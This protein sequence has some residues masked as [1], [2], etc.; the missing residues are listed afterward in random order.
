MEQVGADGIPWASCDNHGSRPWYLTESGSYVVVC[1]ARYGIRDHEAGVRCR[2]FAEKTVKHALTITKNAAQASI[3]A[4]GWGPHAFGQD[5]TPEQRFSGVRNRFLEQ[6]VC[7]D[8]TAAISD[9]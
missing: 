1:R 5:E 2:P 9:Q 6:M 7:I 3:T 8:Y 4:W